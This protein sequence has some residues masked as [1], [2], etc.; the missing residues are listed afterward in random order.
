MAPSASAATAYRW[1][2][3]SSGKCLGVYNGSTANGAAAVQ[4]N[5]NAD[6][7]D[8][9]WSREPVSGR[10]GFYEIRNANSGMCLGTSQGGTS[11]GTAAIQW[12]CNGNP[13]QHWRTDRC[14]V[15]SPE[16]AFYAYMFVN[17]AALN[18]GSSKCLG[19]KDG[20]QDNGAP[21]LIW[22]C[23]NINNNPDQF[24]Q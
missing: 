4:W 5:C 24:W 12:P 21:A 20:V 22:G 2:A 9:Y 6:A 11:N 7:T 14:T 3:A 17:Q 16:G 10:P 15:S 8:Q 13:D 19:I 18:S 23:G 1:I